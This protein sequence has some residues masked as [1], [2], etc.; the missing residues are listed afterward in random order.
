MNKFCKGLISIALSA[1][2]CLSSGISAF[3]T[4]TSTEEAETETSI[5]TIKHTATL[6]EPES[7]EKLEFN[8]WEKYLSNVL[9]NAEPSIVTAGKTTMMTLTDLK[10]TNEHKTIYGSNQG[11]MTTTTELNA[12]MY[13]IFNDSTQ[14]WETPNYIHPSSSG[15]NLEGVM[16]QSDG[17]NIYA[18]CLES[19][20]N[21][22]KGL[23]SFGDLLAGSWPET[24]IALHQYDAETKSFTPVKLI[25]P[26][27][28]Y[29]RM[30]PQLVFEDGAIVLTW[31]EMTSKSIFEIMTKGVD[32]SFGY[33]RFMEGKWTEIKSFADVTI[34]VKGDDEIVDTP[35]AAG[36]IG[37]E[38]VIAYIDK[39]GE[40]NKDHVLFKN[41]H[42][43]LIL[44]KE[45]NPEMI[46][47]ATPSL[48]NGFYYLDEG[49][50][51]FVS[52]ETVDGQ[53]KLVHKE[54]AQNLSDATDIVVSENNELFYTVEKDTGSLFVRAYNSAQGKYVNDR[55]IRDK[56]TPITN[57]CAA[58][59]KDNTMIVILSESTKEQLNLL[60]D[61]DKEECGHNIDYMLFNKMNNSS[62]LDT[63]R[64]SEQDTS[65]QNSTTETPD[66]EV[67]TDA[68]KPSS[69]QPNTTS[70]NYD[71]VKIPDTGISGFGTVAAV[72]MLLSGAAV[73]ALK[74]KEE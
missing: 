44:G 50:L 56:G 16:L 41:E 1:A 70:P 3:A 62:A 48:D 51:Y 29:I 52:R 15:W 68:N 28:G 31:A 17:T 21:S 40:K 36:T 33:T 9:S 35:F 32:V 73:I 59:Y 25:E 27:E 7:R 49:K 4:E 61:I 38:F 45:C 22:G 72:V 20:L 42:G 64:P 34:T 55:V 53:K 63:T 47:S 69:T 13:T 57:L 74:K 71:D 43:T 6:H 23:E 39:Y 67:P 26:K 60:S 58:N 54:L 65:E 11:S 37:G 18:V 24:Q 5:T 12:S 2:F 8:K 30:A 10:E 46:M 19:K 66:K 14:T